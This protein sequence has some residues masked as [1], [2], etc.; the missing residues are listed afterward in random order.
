M[1]KLILASSSP[2]RRFLLESIGYYPDQIIKP[3]I[4][5]QPLKKELPIKLAERLAIA[6]A[7]KV[8][9]SYK[10][11]MVLAVDT[12]I[13]RG[14]M[15]IP[16]P[17]DKTE[18]AQSLRLLSGRRHVVYTGICVIKMGKKI[19]K[20]VQTKLK[21]KLLTDEEVCFFA[22]SCEWKNKSST[23]ELQGIAGAYI[24]WINGHPSNVIGLPVHEVYK[25][26]SGLGLKQRLLNR[27][28]D[29]YEKRF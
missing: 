24:S 21:F 9:D 20:V 16:K 29:K 13:A 8:S 18:A 14:R 3:D 26:L 5:K 6:K 12:V 19:S 4:D 27:A 1:N 7:V 23:Y 22:E 11:A 15:V 25:I 28:V 2:R 10:E 17:K